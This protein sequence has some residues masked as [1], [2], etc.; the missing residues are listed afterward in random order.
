MK[1]GNL[2]AKDIFLAG[3]S[4]GAQTASYV[5]IAQLNYSLGGVIVMD[6]YAL[7]PLVDMVGHTKAEVIASKNA[8]Y[9]GNDMRFMIWEGTEDPIFQPR[10]T[11]AS[12]E[13]VFK[14]LGVPEVWKIRHTEQ[15]MNHVVIAKELAQMLRF[16]RGLNQDDLPSVPD[17][18]V[19]EQQ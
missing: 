13:G 3:Y 14:A 19:E 8:T 7:P 16:V 4:Q 6:G 11:M 18:E 5:Q 2:T 10:P 15:G 12:Y 1:V 17:Q 9:Y